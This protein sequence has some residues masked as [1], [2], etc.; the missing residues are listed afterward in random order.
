[1]APCNPLQLR[2]LTRHSFH[3]LQGNLDT[4]R[5]CDDV[6]SFVIKE[7]LI[8]PDSQQPFKIDKLT[9]VAVNCKKEQS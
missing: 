9:I 1:M 3:F 6:W 4:Y 5:L 8:K 2:N 7:V